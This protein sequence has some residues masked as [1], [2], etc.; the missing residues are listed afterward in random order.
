MAQEDTSENARETGVRDAH[1]GLC[2]A[3]VAGDI[4]ALSALLAADFTLTHMTG[5]LQSKTDWLTDIRTDQMQYHSI[6]T[7]QAVV[8]DDHGTP[9]LTARTHTDATIW[10]GHGL[11]RLQLRSWFEQGDGGWVITRTVASTW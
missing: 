9:V 7:V 10:G 5:Y 1:D 8:I 11:W 6:D 2:D 3:M 4:E